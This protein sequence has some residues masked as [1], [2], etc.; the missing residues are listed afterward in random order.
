MSLQ[1][2]RIEFDSLLLCHKRITMKKFMKWE[3]EGFTKEYLVELFLKLQERKRRTITKIEYRSEGPWYD[4]GQP[5]PQPRGEW[6]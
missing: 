2:S 3:L 6:G 5:C 1:N 4:N